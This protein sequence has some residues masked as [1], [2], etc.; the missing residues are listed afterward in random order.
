[1][2]SIQN[3]KSSLFLCVFC[4]Y[5]HRCHSQ[6]FWRHQNLSQILNIFQCWEINTLVEYKSGIVVPLNQNNNCKFDKIT[7]DWNQRSLLI[8]TSRQVVKVH[9]SDIRRVCWSTWSQLFSR[10]L[11]QQVIS[12]FYDSYWFHR[13]NSKEIS[14]SSCCQ[15]DLSIGRCWRRIR[16]E[17][18]G[19]ANGTGYKW[20]FALSWHQQCGSGQ[21]TSIQCTDWCNIPLVHQTKSY[22]STKYCITQQCPTYCQ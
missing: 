7:D 6:L 2:S 22:C 21:W 9:I 1:M 3:T 13:N 12:L 19:L 4:F 17:S 11:L 8:K 18:G 14:W 5:F 20:I 15:S 16:T 10:Y